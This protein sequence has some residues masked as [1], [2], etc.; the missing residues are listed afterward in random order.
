MGRFKFTPSCCCGGIE[1]TEETCQEAIA[2]GDTPLVS[3]EPWTDDTFPHVMNIAGNENQYGYF[4]VAYCNTGVVESGM[5]I[6]TGYMTTAFDNQT[7]KPKIYTGD[8]TGRLARDYTGN[9]LCA[10]Y[11]AI[12]YDFQN[13][14]TIWRKCLKPENGVDYDFKTYIAPRRSLSGASV[15]YA[16]KD[17]CYCD[18][19]ISRYLISIV[20]SKDGTTTHYF[21]SQQTRAIQHVTD[22]FSN[23][24]LEYV[25]INVFINNCS[26]HIANRSTLTN[27]VE[28]GGYERTGPTFGDEVAR[29]MEVYYTAQRSSGGVVFGGDYNLS[30]FISVPTTTYI[31]DDPVSFTRTQR[32]CVLGTENHIVTQDYS[33][34]IEFQGIYTP[35][36]N[37]ET[38]LDDLLRPNK[39][40]MIDSISSYGSQIEVK[41]TELYTK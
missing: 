14:W 25:S 22:L 34:A 38:T 19:D 37:A 9:S 24:N 7:R 15:M 28:D 6:H 27:I 2:R 29:S 5:L 39:Q 35:T 26:C 33:S 11:N 13:R 32:Y 40:K 36:I 10:L 4:A 3:F 41:Y 20:K 16:D 18:F 1:P 21:T 17:S 12:G 23:G 31:D 30:C 8:Q